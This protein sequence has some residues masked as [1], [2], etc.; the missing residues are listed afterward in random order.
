MVRSA[1]DGRG[2]S[3]PLPLDDLI[4]RDQERAAIGT[5][6]RDPAVRLLTLTGPGGVGKT[7]LAIA[8]ASD[9]G[10][11][12]PDGIAFVN[13][14][15]IRNP[16]L[17]LDTIA[18]ALGLRDMGA[19]SLNDRLI[20]VLAGKRM[21]LVLDNF[22]Q[23]ITAGPRVRELLGACPEVTLLIT[24]RTRL[25]VSGEREFPVDPLPLHTPAIL[26]DGEVSGAVRLFA[27]RAQAVK[28][29][30][31]LT[32]ETLPVVAEI[33]RRVDGLPLAIE[34]A[35]ARMKALPPLALL[36]RLEQRLPLLSGGARDLPLRQQT[37]RDAIAWSYDLLTPAEQAFFRQLSVFVGGFT[38]DAAEWVTGVG[39][40]VS[41]T[42]LGAEAPSPVTRDPL[43]V[44]LDLITSL[45]DHS[46]L[47]QSAGPGHEPR[48]QMLEMVREFGLDRLEAGGEAAT[49]RAAHAAWCLALA[50]EAEP[51]LWGTGQ[52][53]WLDRL[54]RD[55]DNL[56]AALHW[57]LDQGEI[58]T[59][60]RLGAALWRFWERRA[61]LSEG[62]SHLASILALAPNQESFAARCGA[63]TGAGVLAALQGDYD[64]AIQYSEDAL[65]GWRQLG[66]HRGIA[67]SLLCLAAVA[68]YRDDFAVAE[69]LGH[70]SLAAFRTI[71]DR[72]GAGHV[73]AHLGMLAWLQGNHATG[74]AF[75]EEALAHLRDVGDQS[76]IFEIV[77]ELGRGACDAGDLARATAL[78][79]ECLALATS[80][81]D[82]PGRGRA[83]TELGVVAR[84][85]G[86]HARATD[87][88]TRA[89]AL[90]QESGDRRQ[91]AYLAWHLGDVD[92][93][94]GD[95]GSAAARYAAALELFLSM[96]NRVGIAQCLEKL[97][98][99]ALIRGRL[100][101]AARLLGSSTA[102]FSAIGVTPPPDRDPATDVA[103]LKPRLAPAEFAR[104]WD[105]GWALSPA[106]AAAEALA[107]AADFAA[108]T[109]PSS[110]LGG[111]SHVEA[112]PGALP[113][114]METHAG[115]S[116][117]PEVETPPSPR[118]GLGGENPL[119]VAALGLTPRESEVLRL[120][121][122]GLSDR[123]IAAALSISE[124]TAGNHVQHAMQK[125]GVDS[126]TAAA[127]FAVRHDLG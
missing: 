9:A 75:F 79:E 96:G 61:Y 127:V 13:L 74:I 81:G 120:L 123:Q 106:E 14:A 77:L 125:I 8:A 18:G 28:P 111:E 52:V 92:I 100:S 20:G 63:L 115:P 41:G 82:G 23:V 15:P 95:V 22:E 32:V 51:A 107:L 101:S 33:V 19:N 24:S 85:R 124:R 50:E 103:S 68:R 53:G 30:F 42:V 113:E 55:K 104:A 84:L 43:P 35:A 47:R 80:V 56:R 46:L 7:R 105:T 12:F 31:R 4:S 67:R 37:M 66:D 59:A 34:L 73:L 119:P 91:L 122:T 118:G 117:S 116:L 54:D 21:L 5:L 89:T 36:E 6:L 72:W 126:R 88:L 64:Q 78:Y 10:A 86:D 102:M 3:L 2:T 25:R 94:T 60:T 112:P 48:Y 17:V 99:C 65:P 45:I 70:E 93:A 26:E 83:L 121:A 57:T 11:A 38:L 39:Y 62:R 40:Q 27:E 109:P 58:A 87:L 29:D 44:T 71:D 16:G 108:E 114:A 97:A 49:V 98:K 110:G 1:S 69:S 90:A 76:G